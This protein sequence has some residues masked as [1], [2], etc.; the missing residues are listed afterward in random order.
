MGIRKPI[1]AIDGP[2]GAGKSSTAQAAAKRLGFVYIDTGA[3]YR[4]VTLDV[5]NHSVDP[6]NESEVAHVAA[7]SNVEIIMKDGRQ[8]T[9][10]NGNDVSK[11]IRERDVTNAVSV[12]SAQKAV[13]EKMTEFQRRIGGKGGVIMEGRDIGT[14]VFPD[15]EYKLY[16]DASLEV[17]ARRRHRELAEKGTDILV[18]ILIEEIRERDRLNM[19]RSLAPLRKA[20]D[21]VY[22][23]S[24][25]M[26][27]DELV[28]A[29]VS[30]VR[31]ETQ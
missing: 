25:D 8:R 18:E 9:I 12:V 21:A 5:L 20:E 6:E 27:F 11:R 23:D 1:V 28:D 2:V 19:E 26:T 22:I 17:R 4:A 30:I 15:A 7:S 29:I 14:V 31:E 10:L 16:L 24:S 13:R 3:M